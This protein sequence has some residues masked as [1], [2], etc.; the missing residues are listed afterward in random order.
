MAEK[1]GIAEFYINKL[2]LGHTASRYW[3]ADNLLVGGSIVD[4]AD[5][6][7]LRTDFGISAVINLESEHSDIG[8]GIDTLLELPTPDDGQKKDPKLFQSAIAFG[9][10]ILNEPGPK[11]YVHCQQGG[12]RSPAFAYA[13]LR[14]VHGLTKEAAL[15]CI[16]AC[17]PEYGNHP[18]HQAYLDSAEEA[19]SSI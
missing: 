13:I 15:S 6:E 9:Q 5:W 16:R 1:V 7:H 11:L 10:C 8:K 17:H 4:A 18:V 3:L 2:Y 19:L 12:S 14:G